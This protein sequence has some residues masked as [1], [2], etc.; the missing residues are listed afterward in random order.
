M[1]HPYYAKTDSAGS[2]SLKDVPPGEYTVKVWHEKLGEKT[3]KVKVE[4]GKDAKVAFKLAA[5]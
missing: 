5:K 3:E 4:A 1:D 2:F